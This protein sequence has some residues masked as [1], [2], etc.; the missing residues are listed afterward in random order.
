MRLLLQSFESL[1]GKLIWTIVV[2][3]LIFALILNGYGPYLAPIMVAL[4]WILLLITLYQSLFFFNLWRKG[5]QP[6]QRLFLLGLIS[7]AFSGVIFL[8]LTRP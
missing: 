4:R 3:L 1:T 2:T 6:T 8:D 5:E 7:L